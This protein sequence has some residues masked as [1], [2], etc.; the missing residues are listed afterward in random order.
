LADA[1]E[2]L[3]FRPLSFLVEGKEVEE[4]EDEEEV[5]EEPRKFSRTSM[6]QANSCA[7][8]PVCFMLF[9]SDRRSFVFFVVEELALGELLALISV[10]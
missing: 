3:P 2:S 5:E 10:L 4:E 7:K 1:G 6:P 9:M 8:W